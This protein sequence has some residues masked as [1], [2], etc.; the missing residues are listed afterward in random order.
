[1]DEEYGQKTLE[2]MSQAVWYNR[3][4]LNKF[5]EHLRGEILEVGCGI[6]NFT[7]SLLKYG[8]V[9][10]IDI[11]KKYIQKKNNPSK[12]L[13]L[14]FGD[15]EKGKYFFSKK[16]FDTIVCLNVLEHIENDD[17]ALLNIKK[18][19]KSKGKLILLVPVHAKIYGEIDRSIGHF[20]R[21][22]PSQLVSKISLLGFK[23]ACEKQLNLI[24]ALGWWYSGKILKRKQVDIKSINFFNLLAPIF[25]SI[26]NFIKIPFGTSVLLVF[27]KDDL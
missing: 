4:T 26:E 18:L 22:N 21:Y 16:K 25:L 2:S 8:N 1:M 7:G 24:G 23:L 14:G 12:V 15:I 9:W 10:A 13:H 11:N 17:K 6:G 5:E 19:L 20:R 27:K 3:W